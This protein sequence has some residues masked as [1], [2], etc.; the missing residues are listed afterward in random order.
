MGAH[1]FTQLQVCSHTAC[2]YTTLTQRHNT[3]T[4]IHTPPS[5][6]YTCTHTYVCMY[7]LHRHITHTCIH[8]HLWMLPHS[9]IY[10]HS[11]TSLQTHHT[12]LKYKPTQTYTNIHTTLYSI[13][14]A[15][16]YICTH[17]CLLHIYIYIYIYIT[18][19]R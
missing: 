15:L 7:I 18:L 5:N 16:A 11:H 3:C 2:T 6:T 14:Y 1:R 19:L 12:T 9:D 13:Y 17:T 10:M 8:A 4:I